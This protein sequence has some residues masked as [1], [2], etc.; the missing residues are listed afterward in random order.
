MSVPMVILQFMSHYIL[1]WAPKFSYNG[2]QVRLAQKEEAWGLPVQTA[3]S[4][5]PWQQQAEWAPELHPLRLVWGCD[6][7]SARKRGRPTDHEYIVQLFSP[8]L[9][10]MM[11]LQKNWDKKVKSQTPSFLRSVSASFACRS[12]LPLQGEKLNSHYWIILSTKK[13]GNRRKLNFLT[14]L[15]AGVFTLN[16]SLK[17]KCRKVNGFPV[18]EMNNV[19][20]Y[21]HPNEACSQ[22]L[23]NSLSKGERPLITSMTETKVDF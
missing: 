18:I 21:Y 13:Q 12:T 1:P 23:N 6:I 11:T 5:L 2:T 9:G 17:T 14:T 7:F 15:K 10:K 22:S 16:D 8:I 20:I 3:K 4:S 19:I